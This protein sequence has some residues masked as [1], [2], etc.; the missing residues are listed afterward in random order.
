MK[1]EIKAKSGPTNAK[2]LS[3]L[4][5]IECDIDFVE[6]IRNKELRNK[7]IDGYMSFI[8]ENNT[9]YTLTTYRLKE[10]NLLSPKEICELVDYTQGQWSDGIG[11][12]YE[13]MPIALEN[14]KEI[15]L[16]PYLSGEKPYAKFKS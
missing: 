16:S 14:N 9:L 2:D 8:L 10:G 11:E 7:L 3:I 5:G 12:S 15:Y 13:Q 1:I 6:Y 4:N